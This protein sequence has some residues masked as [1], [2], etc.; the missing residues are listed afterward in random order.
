MLE[1]YT[2]EAKRVLLFA[3]YEASQLGS[4]SIQAEHVLIGLIREGHS[5]RPSSATANRII[6]LSGLTYDQILKQIEARIAIGAKVATIIEIPF[7]DETKRVLESAV[8][9]AHQLHHEQVGLEHLLLGLIR[10]DQS[11]AASILGVGRLSLSAARH[12]AAKAV[13]G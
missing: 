6:A 9:E 13:T 7:S 10:E 3:R 4:A 2:E 11:V 5:D 1:R 8:Q 12:E